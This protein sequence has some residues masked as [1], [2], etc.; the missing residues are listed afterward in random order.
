MISFN[1][2]LTLL[3][4]CIFIF[5]IEIYGLTVYLTSKGVFVNDRPV[6]L[7]AQVDKLAIS[8]LGNYI[9]VSG[10]GGKCTAYQITVL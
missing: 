3:Y 2:F 4:T 1:L 10:I 8:L 7:P 9:A 5:Q 6:K